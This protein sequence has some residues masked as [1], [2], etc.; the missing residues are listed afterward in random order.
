MN[1]KI[2]KRLMIAGLVPWRPDM[3]KK[4]R[5]KPKPE[6]LVIPIPKPP[7]LDDIK[8]NL[9]YWRFEDWTLDL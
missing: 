5:L 8:I 3:L 7:N 4:I 1:R 9:A 2:Y 6:P